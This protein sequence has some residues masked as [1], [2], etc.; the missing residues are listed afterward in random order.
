MVVGVGGSEPAG[1]LAA[2][3]GLI[4]RVAGAD[5]DADLAAGAD[6]GHLREI[7][8]EGGE[9][10]AM[11][12][13]LHAVGPDGR[14]LVDGLEAQDRAQPVPV[15]GDRDGAAVPDGLEEVAVADAG[16]LG[17][18]GEGHR[19]LVI[20]GA[21]QQSALTPGVASVDLE[22]PGA[23]EV[24]PGGALQLGARVL[25]ARHLGRGGERG[26][27]LGRELVGAGE[28]RRE[29]LGQRGGRVGH[30]WAPGA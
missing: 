10:A 17:L 22:L 12:G 16:G 7:G 29:L 9:A 1:L 5:D 23:V 25:G 24:Q 13:D 6:A 28:Q 8:G 30:H 15:G 14:V 26:V 2:G 3:L 18:G 4:M 19:D 27:Q 11:T 21:I 20:E